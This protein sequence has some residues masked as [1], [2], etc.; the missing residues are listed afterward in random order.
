MAL[1]GLTDNRILVTVEKVGATPTEYP[2][3]PRPFPPSSRCST[4]MGPANCRAHLEFA[5]SALWV[6]DRY[7]GTVAS[8][9]I[10]FIVVCPQTD[11]AE[12]HLVTI[13]KQ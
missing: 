10:V 4:K 3:R 8:I 12:Y 5:A 6:C 13:S 1:T 7:A 2:R 9:G 11:M